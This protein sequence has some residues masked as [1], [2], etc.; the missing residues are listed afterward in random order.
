MSAKLRYEGRSVE[1]ANSSGSLLSA[2][3]IVDLGGGYL[4]ALVADIPDGKLGWA[5]I[6]GVFEI[7]KKTASQSGSFGDYVQV[8]PATN[9][10]DLSV[11][12]DHQLLE[13]NAAD[14]ATAMVHLNTQ[15]SS[16][17]K[18]LASSAYQ[19][20]LI[21][22]VLRYNTTGG[23]WDVIGGATHDE[24]LVASVTNNTTSITVNH[25]TA[26]FGANP[27]VI[28]C[29][30][31]TDETYTKYGI[32][33]G[34]S[35]TSSASTITLTQNGVSDR[36]QY[37]GSSWDSTRGLF[38]AAWDT[39]R[40]VFTGDGT[41]GTIT[42]SIAGPPSPYI[43]NTPPQVTPYDTP[44]LA[45]EDGSGTISGEVF[46]RVAFYNTTTGARV[47]TEDTNMKCSIWLP[48]AHHILDPSNFIEDIGNIWYFVLIQ[49]DR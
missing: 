3:A 24:L 22:A 1:Y 38:T 35:V 27:K 30:I 18:H 31:N 28:T 41:P 26:K 48:H 20:H 9:N 16:A 39:D 13:T 15:V 23:G 44:Y 25:D 36:M 42:Q 11:E 7:D 34:A 33:A 45:V 10:V 8:L 40:V 5:R 2:G 17:F 29:A 4:G 21:S 12:G 14:S 43:Q 19:Y 47:T 37:N 46:V 6:D 32:R 49:S